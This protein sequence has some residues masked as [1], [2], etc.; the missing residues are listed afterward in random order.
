MAQTDLPEASSDQTITVAMVAGE[1]SGDIL[2]AGLMKSL[3]KRYPNAR[4]EGIGGPLMLAE[5]FNSFYPMER[6]SVMGLV[7]VLGRIFE[8][9]GIRRHLFRHFKSSKPDVFIGIDAPDFNLGLEERLRSQGIKTV[10]YVSPSVWAWRQK[11]V[12][13]IARAV[14]LMLTLLPF[15]AKF[16][17]KHAVQVRFVGHPLADDIPL[18]QTTEKAR[19]VLGLNLNDRVYAILPGSRSGEIKYIGESL[20]RAAMQ[21]QAR[22][23]EA[24]F[25]IPCINEARKEQVAL[26]LE[27]FGDTLNVQ[28][29]DGQSRLAMSASNAVVLAS[30]TAA[31]EAMLLKKPMVVAY[32]VSWLTHRIMKRLLKV[33][34]VSLPNLLANRALV[35]ELLQ[36]A[37]TPQAISDQAIKVAEQPNANTLIDE[38]TSLH[39]TLRLNANE[40]AA[41]AVSELIEGR[42]CK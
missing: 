8:L 7:E 18:T 36:D 19:E 24:K 3:K 40:S 28:L 41:E 34:F 23:P 21:I 33:A 4:F 35:P 2:G 16:Y 39:Q 9:I 13:K 38:F 29:L 25:L 37:A 15:E 26:L 1:A 6:L 10:H 17:E 22:Y 30:G 42:L 5:G 20:I 14:D 31:L 12:F 32:R 11:R 27:Q